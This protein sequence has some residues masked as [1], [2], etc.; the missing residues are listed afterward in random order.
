MKKDS[1]TTSKASTKGLRTSKKGSSKDNK[2]RMAKAR[3]AKTS[4]STKSEEPETTATES[5][6]QELPNERLYKQITSLPEYQNLIDL[7]LEDATSLRH[8]RNG[9]LMLA[10]E[11]ETFTIHSNGKIRRNNLITSKE[12]GRAMVSLYADMGHNITN[13]K[14]WSEA[15]QRLDKVITGRQSRQER[16]KFFDKFNWKSVFSNEDWKALKATLKDSIKESDNPEQYK[17]NQEF[18]S[19]YSTAINMLNERYDLSEGKGRIPEGAEPIKVVEFG[20]EAKGLDIS[21][22]QS[23]MKISEQ[24]SGKKNGGHKFL[25]VLPIRSHILEMMSA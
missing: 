22:R 14:E 19:K 17:M 23:H 6:E 20:K 10:T 4:K 16:V 25:A 1:K 15:L 2:D 21:K 8:R 18:F 12:K 7:G 24:E 3:A 11:T 9:S 5:K 13:Q